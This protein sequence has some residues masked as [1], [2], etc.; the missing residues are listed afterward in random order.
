MVLVRMPSD[1][2]VALEGQSAHTS[3]YAVDAFKLTT[4]CF[5]GVSQKEA[6]LSLTGMQRTP[7]IHTEDV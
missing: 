3:L 4:H 5:F 7:G 6:G 1:R 2:T